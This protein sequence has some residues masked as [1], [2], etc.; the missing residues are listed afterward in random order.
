MECCEYLWKYHRPLRRFNCIYVY[1]YDIYKYI[2]R[3]DSHIHILKLK[4]QFP[5]ETNSKQQLILYTEGRPE[6]GHSIKSRGRIAQTKHQSLARIWIIPFSLK[7]KSSIYYNSVLLLG[8]SANLA[9]G[10]PPLPSWRSLLGL[11]YS[12]QWRHNGRDSVWNHQPHDCLLNRLLRRRS[13]KTSNFPRHWPLCGEFTEDRWI[14]R[15]N[16]QLRG[17]CFHLMTS[18]CSDPPINTLRPRQIGTISE[19]IFSDPFPWMKIFYFD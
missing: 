11:L 9:R 10:A 13:K 19:T 8:L 15:T 2:V 3:E 12:L 16:G 5:S 14:R 4:Q 17:K 7:K 18:S 6:G 1:T